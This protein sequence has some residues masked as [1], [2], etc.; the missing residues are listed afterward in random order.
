MSIQYLCCFSLE[1]SAR[2]TETGLQVSNGSPERLYKVSEAVRK[3]VSLGYQL[4]VQIQPEMPCDGRRWVS[5][6]SC[7]SCVIF[8]LGIQLCSLTHE[9]G[10]TLT[11]YV[12]CQSREDIVRDGRN[13]VSCPRVPRVLVGSF[14]EQKRDPGASSRARTQHDHGLQSHL[15]T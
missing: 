15:S 9:E 12:H 11:T 3:R 7:N 5:G 6:L 13:L 10:V 1:D 4:P 2:Q 14:T 8:P